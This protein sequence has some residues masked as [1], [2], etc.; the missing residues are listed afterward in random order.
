M[1]GTEARCACGSGLQA[2]RC[3][4]LDLATLSPQGS[5]RLLAPI[6]GP[7][8]AACLSLHENRHCARTASHA[9]VTKPIYDRYRYRH[10]IDHS[11][12]AIEIPEPVTA[13]L[14]HGV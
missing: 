11:K 14:G 9:Q 4:Q 2:L 7:F 12:P 3:R 5:A 10:Y 8:D 6:G 13:R 1:L